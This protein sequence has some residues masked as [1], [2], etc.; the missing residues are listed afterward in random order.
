MEL[1]YHYAV[2]KG[3]HPFMEPACVAS[4]TELRYYNVLGHGITVNRG[5]VNCG[6][7]MHMMGMV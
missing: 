7:C 6:K 3:S 1:V 4:R 2:W 5:D